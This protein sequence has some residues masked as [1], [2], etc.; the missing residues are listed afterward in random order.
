MVRRQQVVWVGSAAPSGLETAA[1]MRRLSLIE[2]DQPSDDEL[3]S[4]R[5]AIFDVPRYS[6]SVAKLLTEQLPRCI[7]HGVRPIIRAD[8]AIIKTVQG[9]VPELKER[10]LSFDTRRSLEDLLEEA[11]DAG[12]D[13]GPSYRKD[14][15]IRGF[16]LTGEDLLL[17]QRAFHDCDEVELF[18][19]TEGKSQAIVL[20]VHARIGRKAPGSFTLPFLA[21][22]DDVNNI[23]QECANFEEFVSGHIPFTQRPNLD[24]DRSIFGTSRGILVGDFVEDAVSLSAISDRPE[25][26]NVIYSIFDDALRSW[27]RH[28]YADPAESKISITELLPDVIRP[29]EIIASIRSRAAAFGLKDTPE[30][31]EKR[32]KD[33]SAFHYRRGIIHGDLHPG[34]VMVRGT[35]AILIDFF[36]IWRSAPLVADV[37]CLEVAF[38]FT[39]AAERVANGVTKVHRKEFA[40]WRS[41]IDALFDP[42][43]LRY[44]PPLQEPPS[45]YSWLWSACRQTRGMAHQ[46]GADGA[47]YACALVTYLLRRARLGGYPRENIAVA[48]YALRTAEKVLLCIEKGG[49]N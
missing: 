22:I 4:A 13:P 40:A 18:R 12:F 14:I 35:E 2:R 29:G 48:A 36:G 41:A 39:V 31:L 42:A 44:V 30:N 23:R 37:A 6:G 10:W 20:R 7:V 26:R 16:A 43:C 47:P 49:F 9:L 3:A 11:R 19:L 1:A 15:V 45:R 25:G 17:V 28:A 27:R 34:N 38:C 46:I 32:L 33:V 5:A 24:S 8:S 21:K